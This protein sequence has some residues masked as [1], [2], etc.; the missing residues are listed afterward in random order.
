MDTGILP[1]LNSDYN[2][3]FNNTIMNN[4]WNTGASYRAGFFD[5]VSKNNTLDSNTIAANYIGILL[6]GVA[7]DLIKNNYI[8]QFW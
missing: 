4:G 6:N 2:F 5:W 3:I 7:D 1:F 8:L